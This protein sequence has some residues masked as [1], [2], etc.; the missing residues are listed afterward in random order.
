M[1]IEYQEHDIYTTPCPP[2]TSPF[3]HTPH[4]GLQIFRIKLNR[5]L[6]EAFVSCIHQ[7]ICFYSKIQRS[8]GHAKKA[9]IC[10]KSVKVKLVY[11]LPDPQIQRSIKVEIKLKGVTEEDFDD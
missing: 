1:N 5:G 3:K 9:V 2:S 4:L 6:C 7:F 11:I 10:R 8:E